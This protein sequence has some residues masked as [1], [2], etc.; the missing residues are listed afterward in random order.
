MHIRKVKVEDYNSLAEIHKI[1]FPNFFLTTLGI[2]FLKTYYLHSL[3]TEGS[4]ALCVENDRKEMQGFVVGCFE[5]RGFHKRVFFSSPI[6]FVSSLIKSIILNPK[7][8]IRLLKNVEKKASVADDKNY[9]ELLSI[10]V[11]PDQG[12]KGIGKILIVSFENEIKV[13]GGKKIALTT[14]YSGNESVISFYEKNGYFKAFEFIAYPNR[15]M[16]KMIKEV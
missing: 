6:S 16:Y 10:A 15:L 12:G 8:V 9:S 3:Q 4:I 5:S 13:N 14:D 1:A 2:G 11:R 7:I